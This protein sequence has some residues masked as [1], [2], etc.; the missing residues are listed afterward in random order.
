[1]LPHIPVR[2]G[3]GT[4]QADPRAVPSRRRTSILDRS[5]NKTRNS[6]VGQGAFGFLFSEIIQYTQGRVE[7]IQG[8]EQKLSDLGFGVGV[9]M[10]ELTMFREKTLRRETRVLNIL[11]FI[12]NVVWKA[13]FGKQADALEKSTD[14]DD[15]YMLCDNEPLVNQ[16]ISVPKEMAQFNCNAYIAGVIEGILHGCQCVARVTAHT[17]PIDHKPLRTVFLI[18]LGPEVVQK[19]EATK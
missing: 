14:N 11:Y 3:P 13:L 6:E 15:E 16:F 7:G 17:V 19:E 2:I 5:L 9:R 4:T 18:K 8:F 10:L 1:M 12:H